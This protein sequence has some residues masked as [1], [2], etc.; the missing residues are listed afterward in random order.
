LENLVTL[1]ATNNLQAA[2]YFMPTVLWRLA[3]E[4][5]NITR[6]TR[7]W[8]L[9]IAFDVVRRCAIFCNGADLIEQGAPDTTVGFYRGDDI[10]KSLGSLLVLGSILRLPIK[11][12]ALNRVS[13][14]GLEDLFGTTRDES[15]RDNHAQKLIHRMVSPEALRRNWPTSSR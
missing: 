8:L 6:E 5:L 13:S 15:R 11:R 12:I 2:L 14:N 4:A 10:E 1:L 3:I 7:F 9:N